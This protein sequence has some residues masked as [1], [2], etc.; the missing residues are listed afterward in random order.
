MKNRIKGA[1]LTLLMLFATLY[2]SGQVYANGLSP[3]IM[4]FFEK[5]DLINQLAIDQDFV[6][7][8]IENFLR[9]RLTLLQNNNLSD[10]GKTNFNVRIK[11][12]SSIKHKKTGANLL[13][14]NM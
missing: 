2:P 6:I 11:K 5:D 12:F 3:K 8:T 14:V 7:L 10:G 9:P 4:T 13:Q 1:F